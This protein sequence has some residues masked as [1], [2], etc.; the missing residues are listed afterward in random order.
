[1]ELK[2]KMLSLAAQRNKELV[3]EISNALLTNANNGVVSIEQLIKIKN[4]AT[5]PE[6]LISVLRWL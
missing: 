1:M 5:S 4:L 6:R 3:N 2:I